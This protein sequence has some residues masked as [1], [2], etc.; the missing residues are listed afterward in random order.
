[1][2]ELPEYLTVRCVA[3][4][5]GVPLPMAEK[6]MREC[7]NIAP[8]RQG[9]Y[10]MDAVKNLLAG[11][12]ADAQ[13]WERVKAVATERDKPAL[14]QGSKKRSNF[15]FSMLGIPVPPGT[16]LTL[17]GHDAITCTVAG[18]KE[19]VMFRGECMSLSRSATV[20]LRELGR[21]GSGY[22]GPELWCLHGKTLD[23]WRMEA[24]R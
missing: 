11:I 19:Y 13:K 7:A 20:A 6:M 4:L 2:S 21:T 16:I 18:D 1:M 12:V 3:E 8:T 22:P 9:L 23:D 5:L 17:K 14:P 24:G 15:S 10:P